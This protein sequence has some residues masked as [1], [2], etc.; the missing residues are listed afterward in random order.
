VM[1]Y[2]EGETLRQIINR[3]TYLKWNK[4]KEIFKTLLEALYVCH[5]NH[6]IHKDIKP[7]NIMIKTNSSDMPILIDFGIAR[8]KKLNANS[9]TKTTI[10]GTDLYMAPEQRTERVSEKSD[11]YSLG[12]TLLEALS[13]E[14]AIHDDLNID[15]EILDLIERH[16]LVG[17]RIRYSIEEFYLALGGDI[18]QLKNQ[19]V[20]VSQGIQQEVLMLKSDCQRLEN[21]K[22]VIEEALHKSYLYHDVLKNQIVEKDQEIK[23][24]ND[25]IKLIQEELNQ[26]NIAL[27]KMQVPTVKSHSD[28]DYQTQIKNVVANGVEFNM[29]YCPPGAFLMKSEYHLNFAFNVKISKGFWMGETQVTQELWQSIMG[30]NPSSFK[31]SMQLPIESVSWYDCL[32]LCNKLSELGGFKM[33]YVLSNVQMDGMHIKSANVEWKKDANGYRLPTEAEWEYS[34]KAGTQFIYAGSDQIDEVAWYSDNSGL[35][36]HE[37]KTKKPNTWGFYDMSGN[38][39]ECCHDAF[40]KKIYKD[41]SNIE[42]PV[43][44]NNAPCAHLACGGSH[45]NQSHENKVSSRSKYNAV[46]RNNLMGLRLLKCEP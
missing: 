22:K 1:E 9:Q 30:W 28:W 17:T 11:I 10:A 19:I 26:L 35:K 8:V 32:V 4:A 24:L 43:H 38:V 3:K 46:S 31:G 21:E 42:N 5:Q 33:S 6:I 13:G 25:N 41:K 29:I 15:H 45:L 12:I 2:I 40:H 44:W 34:A 36:T 14:C 37:V 39:W 18:Q 27:V 16:L 20:G 7:D 23:K